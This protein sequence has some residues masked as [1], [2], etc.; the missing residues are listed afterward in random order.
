MSRWYQEGQPAET[1][2][3]AS[4]A[5]AALMDL[6][7]EDPRRHIMIVRKQDSSESGQYSVATIMVCR[8]PYTDAEIDRLTN[9]SRDLEFRPVLTPGFA[10]LPEFDAVATRAKYKTLI[11]T[12]PL[13]IGAPTD[14]TPFFFHMLR[15]SDLMKAST[16]QGMNDINLKAVN[17]LGTLI[18]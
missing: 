13:N 1:L 9:I 17:D 10:E 2:R 8:R 7:I 12:Y 14:D 16:Y 18:C 6:G 3:L 5:T 11:A 15:A 4:L